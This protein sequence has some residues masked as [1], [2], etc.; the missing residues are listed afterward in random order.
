MGEDVT[1]SAPTFL[2]ER[3]RT[4]KAKTYIYIIFLDVSALVRGEI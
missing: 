3:M 2:S 1:T 4:C